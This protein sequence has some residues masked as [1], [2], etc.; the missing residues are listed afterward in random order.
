MTSLPPFSLSDVSALE[1][2]MLASGIVVCIALVT[3]LQLQDPKPRRRRERRER[4]GAPWDPNAPILFYH[5]DDPYYEFT[6]FSPHAVEF[7]GKIYPTSEHLFQAHKFLPARPDLA[8][9]IRRTRSPRAALEEATRL[10]RVQRRDW[11]DVNIAMMDVV[12]ER[13]FTQD[14][15]LKALLLDTGER[16][17]VEDSPVDSFW[18]CGADGHGRNELGKALVRLRD[19]LRRRESRSRQR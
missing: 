13:K 10:R 11:Y 2:W 9:R 12:L 7:E 17:L 14:A 1:P 3:A 19:K 18:G 6:N 15:R 8:D 16:E 4:R 5:R